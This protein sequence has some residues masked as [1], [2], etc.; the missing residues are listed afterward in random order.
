M[1]SS[2]WNPN[3]IMSFPNSGGVQSLSGKG[4]LNGWKEESRT[5]SKHSASAPWI[6]KPVRVTS[7]KVMEIGPKGSRNELILLDQNFNITLINSTSRE[8]LP[9]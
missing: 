3:D 9:W 6:G 4:N 2:R 7:L 8:V 1:L 5:S